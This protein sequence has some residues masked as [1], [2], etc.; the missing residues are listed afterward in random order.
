MWYK[1]NGGGFMFNEEDKEKIHRALS[2]APDWQTKSGFTGNKR[3]NVH[4]KVGKNK[5]RTAHLSNKQRKKLMALHQ[6]VDD[7][8]VSLSKITRKE[9]GKL[10]KK[11]MRKGKNVNEGAWGVH[12][13]DTY[14]KYEKNCK[15]FV[16]WCMEKYSIN[17]L[18]EIRPGMYV[19]FIEDM[20]R[21]I[22]VNG[23]QGETFEYS[24]KTIGSYISAIEKMVE[25]ARENGHKNLV[26]LGS[27]NI[28]DK[29]DGFRENYS[30]KN[31]KRGKNVNG[32]LG[33]SLR[34]A[35]TITKKAYELSPFYG[36]MYEVLT[37]AGPRL[38]E[39][40]GVKWRQLDLENNRIY[41]DDPNQT[42]GSR[43][44]FIPIPEK[45]SAKLKELMDVAQPQNTDTRIWGSKL[46]EA[47]LRKLTKHCC[48]EGKIGYSGIH[49]FRRSAVEYHMRELKKEYEKKGLTKA[50]IVNRILDHVGV[51][52]RLNPIVPKTVKNGYITITRKDGTTFRKAKREVVEGEFERKYRFEE[53]ITHRIDFLMNTLI[54][55][56]LGHNR[57]D[58]TS[59]YKNG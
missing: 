20:T 13:N 9:E 50:D 37:F 45:T 17:S 59:P 2:D 40:R 39:L 54:A 34:E 49:D 6:K 24:P 5:R 31:Y 23:K 10:T 19:T 22:K 4:T 3:K 51:D 38:D 28:R 8:F 58:S 55:E 48:S 36:A 52:D 30:K 18:D 42:K 29:I 35:Q 41:L 56:T 53:L 26:K 57:T 44:R 11:D 25:G 21:G 14:V 46:T 32:R 43:P 27:D 7:I 16:K 15:A 47:S 12:S 33:Y 1:V